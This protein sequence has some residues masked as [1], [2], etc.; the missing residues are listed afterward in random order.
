MQENP[1]AQEYAV[2]LSDLLRMSVDESSRAVSGLLNALH[3]FGIMDVKNATSTSEFC[4]EDLATTPRL[5]VIGASLADGRRSEVLSATMLSRCLNVV[6]RR[7]E[8]HSAERTVPIYFVIDEA[9]RLRERICYDEA[10][11]VVR[12]ANAGFCLA[13]QDLTQFGAE[14]DRTT[15]LANC[16]A[17]IVMR[18]CSPETADVFAAR[19]GERRSSVISRTQN[20]LP[21]QILANQYGQ[22]VSSAT[23]AVLAA[24]EIMSPPAACGRYCALVHMRDGCSKPLLVRFD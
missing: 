1:V 7:F 2:D 18:G 12:S 14:K 17:L 21:G 19:L 10:L 16:N 8:A 24:R 9:A 13:V 11:S 15:I 6:Y 4:L 20:R 5:L 22:T 23:T 3:V